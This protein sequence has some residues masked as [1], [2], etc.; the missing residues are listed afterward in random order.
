[1]KIFEF[2]S[3]EKLPSFDCWHD[4]IIYLHFFYCRDEFLDVL[5]IR[6][7]ITQEFVSQLCTVDFN[8]R[9]YVVL[10][11]LMESKILILIDLSIVT[12]TT[13]FVILCWTSN[14]LLLF[15]NCKNEKLFIDFVFKAEMKK[16]R[17]SL[18]E[19]PCGLWKG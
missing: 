5:W 10:G 17:H 12:F 4:S 19:R 1:M 14:L 13:V 16:K 7:K 6:R 15:K 8:Y 3:K 9:F 11:D 2:L 18:K